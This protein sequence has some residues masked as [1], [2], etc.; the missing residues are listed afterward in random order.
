MA[1]GVNGVNHLADVLLGAARATPDSLA[2]RVPGVRDWSHGELESASAQ[3]AHALVELGVEPGDRVAVQIAKSAETIALHLACIR[4]GAM[5]LPLNSSYTQAELIALLDDA[6]PAVLIRDEPLQ[7]HVPTVAL[8]ALITLSKAH[9]ASFTDVPRSAADP[10][11][12]LYTSGTTGRPKGA[13]LS[14]GNLSFS[15]RCLVDAWGFTAEDVLLHILPLFH[16]HGLYVAVHTTL[17]SGASMILHESFDPVRIIGDLPNATIMMGVPTHYVRLLAEPE[18]AREVASS[19][20]LFTSGSAP[21]L[22]TTHREFTDRTGQVI[23]ERYGMTETCMLTSNP[24][25]G[26][27]RPGTVGPPLAGV[28]LRVTSDSP[29]GIEVRGP[30]VFDG[31]WRRPELKATEFT[32]DGWFRTGDL[33]LIDPDGYVEIVGRSKD[34]IISG[35]LNVYP[36]EVELL[37]D[38]LAG[39]EESAV[40]GIA[41]PDFGEAVVAVV[42]LDG[43]EAV[44]PESIRASARARLAGFKVPKQVFVVDSLPRNAMGKVE[45]AKLR[46]TYG[47][48]REVVK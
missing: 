30:N 19:V 28:E 22:V 39:I 31:Y 14:H 35:G 12:I 41:D 15:A 21:M 20:R 6:E 27:R 10:A 2:I 34:L 17:A 5:Y 37:L 9:P 3:I 13:V 16:T 36:K 47:S 25:V 7:H 24:L 26:E 29:G 4:A 33:G 8:D 44:T 45:K 23:L 40:V 11:S 38:S 46:T 48:R 43:T 1:T 42:V 18:F 32:A